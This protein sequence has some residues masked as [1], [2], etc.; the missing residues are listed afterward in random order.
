M[1]EQ[2]EPKKRRLQ[3]V[4]ESADAS[5]T[6][7]VGVHGSHQETLQNLE[8]IL[9]ETRVALR[10]DHVEGDSWYHAKARAR[11]A[12]RALA[13]AIKNLRKG[14]EGLERAAFA[15]RAYEEKVQALPEERRQKALAK[16]QKKNPA[17]NST[18]NPAQENPG[19]VPGSTN[20][21]YPFP[22][23]IADIHGRESA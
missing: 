10:S 6:Y 19:T 3:D 16:E 15:R 5:A 9:R 12:E 22:T 20:V 14:S 11:P 23:S 18:P 13:K 8:A 1:T 7:F 4:A 17:L 21:S 2:Q